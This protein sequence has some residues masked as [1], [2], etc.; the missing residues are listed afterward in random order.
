MY[1]GVWKTSWGNRWQAGIYRAGK[2]YHLGTFED[3]ESAA[4]AYDA[5]AATLLGSSAVL[6]FPS[7][8]V[9]PVEDEA[10]EHS[11]ADPAERH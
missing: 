6:N 9:V 3:E 11:D 5:A 1:R 8:K 2:R 7:D 4:R 10:E